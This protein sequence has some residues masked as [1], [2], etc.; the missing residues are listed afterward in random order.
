MDFGYYDFRRNLMLV[1]KYKS[2]VELVLDELGDYD[3]LNV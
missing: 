3:P 1:K 2:N